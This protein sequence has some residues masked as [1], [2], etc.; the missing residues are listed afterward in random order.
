M[1][2]RIA[3][4]PAQLT[5]YDTG[6]SEFLQLRDEARTALGA[7]FDLRSFHNQVLGAGF[8]PLKTLGE[9]TRAW[10]E[11]ERRR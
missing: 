7:D 8:V 2:D 5:A 9:L 3:V 1:L 6:G 11:R 10:I 4:M